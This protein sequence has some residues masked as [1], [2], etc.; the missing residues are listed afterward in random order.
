MEALK[1]LDQPLLLQKFKL[2]G[3]RAVEGYTWENA[4]QTLLEYYQRAI[5]LHDQADQRYQA[6]I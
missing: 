2:A 6:I 1:V 3:R 5:D 4:S